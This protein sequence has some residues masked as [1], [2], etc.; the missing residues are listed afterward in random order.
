MRF[1]NLRSRPYLAL[2]ICL[3]ALIDPA[4]GAKIYKGTAVFTRIGVVIE[5]AESMTKTELTNLQGKFGGT[6]AIKPLSD[7]VGAQSGEQFIF[8]YGPERIDGKRLLIRFTW[9]PLQDYRI[10]L[11]WEDS[12]RLEARGTSPLKPAPYPIRIVELDN[13]LSLLA[14]LQRPATP[15][16]VA[17]SPGGER[18]A[19]ASNAGHLTIINPLTGDEIWKTR[20]SEGYAKHATFSPYGRRLYIGEQSADGF[21]YA[22]DL[23]GSRPALLW[24][25]RMADDIDTSMPHNPNDVYAWVQ[26]PGPYRITV[27]E[28]DDLLVA[29]NHSWT[30][31]GVGL[32]KAQLY[33]FDG[34]TGHRKWKWPRTQILPM[35][36]SWFDHSRDG[37]TIALLAYKRG[38]TDST[39]FKPGT[40][41]IID[42]ETGEPRWEYTFEPL[43]PYFEEVTFWRGVSVSPDGDFVNVTTDDG[44]AFI[45]N[46][47]PKQ[48]QIK[49]LWETA[50]T[51]PL[52][53][54]GIPI[55]AT[56][57]TVGGTDK[58]AFFVTGDTF[59]PYHLQKGAQQPPSAH[60]NGM[61]L[62]AYSWSGE[63][64]W[65]WKLE[66]M[67][68]GLRVDAAGRYAAVSVSRRGGNIEDQLHG[69]SLFDSTAK[70]GGLAKYLYTYR[71]EGQLPYDTIDLSADGRFIAVIETPVVMPD[72]TPC[73]KN[74]VHVLQ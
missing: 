25:Y 35:T 50:L 19:I 28:S 63:K 10:T 38:S 39:Q 30:R 8:D 49:P 21:I 42:G 27:T 52:E 41:Y 61:T 26:Y 54:S 57:G 7:E 37:K 44:R 9:K 5:L 15:T 12:S 73:G 31:D 64:I 18:L 45:F 56:S 46:T 48:E 1:Q 40:L 3:F 70:G 43:K 60:P 59:I 34:E 68:Q 29:G 71:T 14:N 51:T 55:I 72:E 6:L 23:S 66:N 4:A 65:Q 74:R 62:F 2:L 58:L 24:K 69:V 53:V 33:R 11:K 67:P 47:M 36:I 16:T 20:I 32:K 13:S 17:F 22:Y